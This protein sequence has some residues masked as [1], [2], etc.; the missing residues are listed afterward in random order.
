M[1]H[2]KDENGFLVV[3]IVVLAGL[4]YGIYQILRGPR[5]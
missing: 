3:V 5:R 4:A 1:D 2:L